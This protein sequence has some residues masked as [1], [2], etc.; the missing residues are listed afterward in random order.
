VLEWSSRNWN[1][2]AYWAV[3]VIEGVTAALSIM[4]GLSRLALTTSRKNAYD[5][6]VNK[7]YRGL[8]KDFTPLNDYNELSQH[9]PD[10]TSTDSA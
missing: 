1:Y 2:N 6:L 9:R 3:P 8:L 10:R 5:R 7:D 4:Q